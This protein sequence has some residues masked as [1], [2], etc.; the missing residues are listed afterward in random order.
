MFVLTAFVIVLFVAF[1]KPVLILVVAKIVPVVKP[2][3]R[4]SVV[5]L[6]FVLTAFVIVLFVAFNKSVE[7]LVVAKI[8]P[9]VIPV[10]AI[11]DVKFNVPVL[12]AVWT[13]FVIVLLVP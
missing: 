5:E 8:V 13:A 12:K 1:N 7:I 3:E 4:L 10:L 6:M 2:V 9:V 11:A